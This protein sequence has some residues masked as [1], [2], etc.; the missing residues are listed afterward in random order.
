MLF[1]TKSSALLILLA[2]VFATL[3]HAAPAAS[4]S[5]GEIEP[6]CNTVHECLQA[7]ELKNDKLEGERVNKMDK[8]EQIEMYRPILAVIDSLTLLVDDD[9]D[10]DMEEDE[11][12]E[13]GQ[14][15]EYSEERKAR[16]W[17]KWQ[18]SIEGKL[19][20]PMKKGEE[21]YTR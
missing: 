10:E 3:T 4:V 5:R 16:Y 11:E 13:N 17:I 21:V 14:Y 7:I 12:P 18:K 20:G 6:E 19:Y 2:L 9:E 8:D 15:E 1:Q